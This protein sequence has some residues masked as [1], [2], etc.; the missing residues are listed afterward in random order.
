MY[1]VFENN[2]IFLFICIIYVVIIFYVV[3]RMIR[4]LN[5]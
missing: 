3:M 2:N 1:G 4:E 5:N